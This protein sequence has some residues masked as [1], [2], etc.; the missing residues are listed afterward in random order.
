MIARF[1]QIGSHVRIIINRARDDDVFAGRLP[2]E[3]RGHID[4]RAE[5]VET[6][7]QRDRN[8]RT[9]VQTRFQPKRLASRRVR[10]LLLGI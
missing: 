10:Q 1:P 8:A 2:F 4:G 9:D 6:I 3:A 7:I 5:I